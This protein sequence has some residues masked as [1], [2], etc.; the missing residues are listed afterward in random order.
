MSLIDWPEPTARSEAIFA[1]DLEEVGFVMNASRLWAY[2]PALHEGMFEL[3][4]QLVHEHGLSY[5][6]RGIL[7]TAC[8]SA[9]GDSYCSVA[10]GTK[11]ARVANEDLAA[12]VLRGDD[13]GLSPA[14]HALAEWA[15]KVARDP[16]GTSAPDVRALQ[17][18]GWTDRQIF[19][20][21]AFVALRIAFSTINDALGARPDAEYRSVAPPAVLKEITYGRPLAD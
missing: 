4:R 19:A 2:Q 17:D 7:V 10:W 16:N 20:I 14:E 5:R 21:T 3:L 13:F 8:A 1:D 9:L 11:L 12:G 18:S 15:R 6:E